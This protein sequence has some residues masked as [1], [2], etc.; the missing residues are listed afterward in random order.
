[1]ASNATGLDESDESENEEDFAVDESEED[2][3]VP[4][5]HTRALSR[6]ISGMHEVTEEH[7]TPPPD[8]VSDEM[9]AMEK[10]L[11]KKRKARRGDPRYP[12][13]SL[14]TQPFPSRPSPLPHS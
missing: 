14:A 12:A 3:L 8:F 7:S 10:Q 11:A 4:L 2:Q 6:V 5:A 9:K 13:L 1:M